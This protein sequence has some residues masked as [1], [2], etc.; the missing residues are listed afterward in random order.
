M[1]ALVVGGG[2]MGLAI[3]YALNKLGLEVTLTDLHDVE[4]NAEQ[5]LGQNQ[6]SFIRQS[7]LIIMKSIHFDVCISAAPFSA[8]TLWAEWCKDRKIP[9]CDLGGNQA[10]SEY[11]QQLSCSINSE[12]PVFTDLGLAPGL[13][14]ILAEQVYRE[15]VKRDDVKSVHLRVGGLPQYYS[16]DSKLKYSQVFSVKGLL[17]EYSGKCQIIKKGVITEAD[18]LTGL[19]K[20]YFNNRLL[21]CFH[22]SGGLSTTLGLMAARKV[23]NLT[24]K[25][26]RYEGHCEKIRFI[27]EECKLDEDAFAAV[28][29]K[30]CPPTLKDKVFVYV[31]AQGYDGSMVAKELQIVADDHWEKSQ[32]WTAMQKATAFPAAVVAKMM[33]ENRWEKPVL[34]YSDIPFK[35]FAD[36]LLQLNIDVNK[37]IVFDGVSA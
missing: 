27:L 18:A 2:K 1:N 12:T 8:N 35:E 11:I 5:I 31:Y 22:T 34:D 13:A 15:Q 23:E 37:S 30:A 6:F 33:A 10:I 36:T 9:Y 19:E 4:K 25:T 29:D 20:I 17:N 21:E 7:E 3:V 24:Y 32:Q 14:N 28:M 16:N 26:I